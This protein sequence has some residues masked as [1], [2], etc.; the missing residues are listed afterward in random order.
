MTQQITRTVFEG[1]RYLLQNT[2][3]SQEL[4]MLLCGI[5]LDYRTYLTVCLI[6]IIKAARNSIRIEKIG[7]FYLF[8]TV[9]LKNNFLKI[10]N[11]VDEHVC[12]WLHRYRI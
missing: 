10:T 11:C 8:Y 6:K 7:K 9:R 12:A 5:D 4:F 1:T 2:S 3:I